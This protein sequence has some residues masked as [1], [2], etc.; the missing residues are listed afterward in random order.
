[1]NNI[2]NININLTKQYETKY[3]ECT[4]LR[5]EN[6][7]LK[8]QLA[9]LTT[10]HYAQKPDL[11]IG[12]SLLRGI[13]QTKLARTHVTSLPGAKIKDVASNLARTEN[14]YNRIVICTGT[15][16]CNNDINIDAIT[17]HLDHLLQ[18]ATE[19]VACGSNVVVSSIP[20]TTEYVIRQQRVEELN[21]IL[22]DMSAKVGVTFI[23]NDKSFRLAD[24]QPNDGYLCKDGLHLNYRG[25]SRLIDNLRLTKL[26]AEDSKPVDNN[27][28]QTHS[29]KR[30]RAPVPSHQRRLDTD[31][32]DTGNTTNNTIN[33]GGD[34]EDTGEFSQPWTR[35]KSK[36]ND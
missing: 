18:V 10:K 30:K 12:D 2:S 16:D 23:S 11:V 35:V 13:H 26:P 25:T 3:A 34:G 19:R 9:D 31:N 20:P 33:D 36:A 27:E 5:N 22:Q 17:E 21:T 8:V 15:N 24:R 1:M 6:I 32:N 28:R 29:S 7:E 14:K 4:C